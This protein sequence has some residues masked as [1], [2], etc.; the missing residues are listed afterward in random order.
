MILPIRCAAALAAALLVCMAPV[1]GR[2]QP[3]PQAAKITCVN[4]ASG[5]T[6]QIDVDYA[7]KTVDGIPADIDADEIYWK[8]PKD[9]RNYTLDRKT[10][11][12][13]MIAASST[14]GSIWFDRC[15]LP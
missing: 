4:P 1:R 10:G 14:G 7:R 13:T 5:A 15:K 8:D 11:K 12:L 2:A 9:L 3:A 6:W